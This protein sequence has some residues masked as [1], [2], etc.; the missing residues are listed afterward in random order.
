MK[1]FKKAI[2][3]VLVAAM[4]ICMAICP[5][6]AEDGTY[7]AT[8]DSVGG[9]LTVKV[10]VSDGKLASVEV[11]EIY[12]TEGVYNPVVERLPGM[13]VENQSINVDSVSGATLSSMFLK[14]AVK[15]ALEK[16]SLNVDD[17][18]EKVAY[19]APAQADM[20]ADVV[21]V[22]AGMAGLGAT[23]TLAAKGY[24]VVLLE[25]QAYVGGNAIPSDQF[26]I[27]SDP[28]HAM[29]DFFNE[30]GMDVVYAPYTTLVPA[31]FL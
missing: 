18:N 9:P 15:Q 4:V 16:A 19:Q 30:N 28:D 14:N 10:T 20:E 2:A 25:E 26:S 29:L 23:L 7:E 22:G 3:S 8:V 31:P 27:C 6:F 17:F 12:D 1:N 21:V 24:S 13:M 5:A 11:T